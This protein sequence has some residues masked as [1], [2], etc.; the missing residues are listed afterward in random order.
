MAPIQQPSHQPN[1][2]LP[3]VE[4]DLEENTPAA[5][6]EEIAPIQ[7]SLTPQTSRSSAGIRQNANGNLNIDGEEPARLPETL[8]WYPVILSRKRSITAD[9]IAFIAF[10]WESFRLHVDSGATNSQVKSVAGYHLYA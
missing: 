9:D 5:E 1:S 4:G 3:A 8:F 7:A 2:P 6:H 10:L